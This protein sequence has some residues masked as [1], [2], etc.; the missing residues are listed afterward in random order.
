MPAPP[1][2]SIVSRALIPCHFDQSLYHLPHMKWFRS[3]A[4]CVLLLS[5]AVFAVGPDDEYVNLYQM[6]EEADHFVANNQ[7]TQARAR[8]TQIQ[9]ALAKFRSTYPAW[10][11][12]AVEF[13]IQYVNDKLKQ[14]TPAAAAEPAKPATTAAPADP[15]AE[16]RATIAQ[17]QEERKVLNAKLQE[18]LAAQPAAVDPK[19]LQK[20]E[21]Q[22]KALQK[23]KELL[24]VA[25]EQEQGKTA[26]AADKSGL[27]K[28]NQEIASLRSQLAAGAA[29]ATAM[30]RELAAAR[31]SARTNAAAVTDLQKALNDMRQERDAVLARAAAADRAAQ[32]GS[33][34]PTKPT[35][36]LN[37]QVKQLEKE[38][39]ELLKRLNTANQQNYEAQNKNQKGA[40]EKENRQ[41]AV[42]RA[43][44][45]VLEG[46]K[47]PYTPEE[48]ALFKQPN[49]AIKPAPAKAESK[50]KELPPGAGLLITD[51]QRAFAAKQFDKAEQKYLEVL[52]MDDKNVFTLANLGAIQLE[53]GRLND[54]EATLNKAQAIDPGDSFVIG[55]LGIVR[56]RQ[57]K[58]DEAFDLLSRAVDLD[59]RNAQAYNFLGV[60]LSQKGQRAA[61]ET[62]L[63]KALEIAPT[64]PDAHF[65][66]AVIYA[67][68]QPPFL[69]LARYHYQKAI[70]LGY[71]ANPEIEKVIN[72]PKG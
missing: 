14:L 49:V 21:E 50:K 64:M 62:A 11:A 24:K 38:R 29:P 28:A 13:R 61:A 26:Q 67:T 23:E 1:H 43:R 15:I 66:L 60:T 51:A 55:S 72:A 27:E 41:I 65:N 56:F 46:R 69:E 20:A 9:A 6:I 18:A 32:A 45:E 59:P 35:G 4:V 58:Y 57:Q 48:L 52:K 33:V 37:S 53:M 16:M 71:P 22:I 8:Y 31:E 54:A 36:D 17:L 47:V 39:D 25:L 7:L 3:I 12:A 30:E 10:N 34:V 70:S 19:E 42:L 44:L 68:Q 40:N 2:I 5:S 63:R